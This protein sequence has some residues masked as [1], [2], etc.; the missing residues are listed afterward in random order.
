MPE[1]VTSPVKA[2]PRG[3]AVPSVLIANRHERFR[4]GV[5]TTPRVQT[6]N[7]RVTRR[8]YAD[9]DDGRTLHRRVVGLEDSDHIQRPGLPRHSEGRRHAPV[10][11]AR[12][13]RPRVEECPCANSQVVRRHAVQGR[14][15]VR[16]DCFHVATTRDNRGGRVLVVPGHAAGVEGERAPGGDVVSEVGVLIE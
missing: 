14:V 5:R 2:F 3:F 6:D 1:P 7:R 4:K 15:P 16:I 11:G 10:S 13:V 8:L 12:M 9:G